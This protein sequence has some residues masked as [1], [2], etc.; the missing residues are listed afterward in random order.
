M[1][2]DARWLI[3]LFVGLAG[4]V[5]SYIA[6]DRW[7]VKQIRDGDEDVKKA[8]KAGDDDLH[9]RINRTRDEYVRRDD[10]MTHIERIESTMREMRMEMHNGNQELLRHLAQDR[11]HP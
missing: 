6:R 1:G 10:L 2:D 11:G 8:V 9:S 4:L 5:G 7:L 3:G